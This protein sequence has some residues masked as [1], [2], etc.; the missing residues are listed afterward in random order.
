MAKSFSEICE[1]AKF[2][3][4]HDAKGK[5]ADHNGSASFSP[6]KTGTKLQPKPG[7]TIHHQGGGKSTAIDPDE[8]VNDPPTKEEPKERSYRQFKGS[9]DFVKAELTAEKDA[10]W[11]KLSLNKKEIDSVHTYTTNA[12]GEINKHLR[13][14]ES[15][16]KENKDHIENLKSVM[17]KS[18]LSEGM[19]LFRGSTTEAL[20]GMFGTSDPKELKS[21]VGKT[22]HDKAFV[23]TTV[24]EKTLSGNVTFKIKAAAGSK[25]LIIDGESKFPN[26][27]EILLPAGSKFKIASIKVKGKKTQF[28]EPKYVIEL[29]YE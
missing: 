15:T 28:L 12:F 25:G 6:G 21:L 16:T 27:N 14:N 19:Q 4:F 18:T 17:E 20:Q 23:S 24:N 2:N 10:Q 11:D 26:E 5:F 29:E 22:V 8:K 3:P 1:L 7:T 9:E 13:S